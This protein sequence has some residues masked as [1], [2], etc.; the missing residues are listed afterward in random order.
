MIHFCVD[1]SCESCPCC[2]RGETNDLLRDSFS[3]KTSRDS[4]SHGGEPAT[5]FF[6]TR[7]STVPVGPRQ[8]KQKHKREEEEEE[9][10]EELC[11]L[12]VESACRRPIFQELLLAY[13]CICLG[14][15]LLSAPMRRVLA[16]NMSPTLPQKSN[17]SLWVVQC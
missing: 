3:R 15:R 17:R 5:R 12:H 6:G 2:Y 4:D 14:A 9:E 8:K 11:A 10:E 13:A 16:V 1:E 7:G